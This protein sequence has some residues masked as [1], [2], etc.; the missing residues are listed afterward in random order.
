MELIGS[1]LQVARLMLGLG[2][3]DIAA[4]LGMVQ[5]DISEIENG[6]RKFLKTEYLYFLNA[7]GISLSA[8]FDDSVSIER[9]KELSTKGQPVPVHDCQECK[10]KDQQISSLR[11]VNQARGETIESLQQLVKSLQTK[12]N[13]PDRLGEFNRAVN[14]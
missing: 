6:K 10:M 12:Q 1:K 9:F 5:G 14:G 3:K 2:Q 13:V 7:K 8:L 4:P 11:E